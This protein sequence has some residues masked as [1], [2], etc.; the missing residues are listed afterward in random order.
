MISFSKKRF[1]SIGLTIS[2]YCRAF[3]LAQLIVTLVSMPILIA[4]GIPLSTMTFV[5]NLLFTPFISLFLLCSS[6]LFFTELCCIPNQLIAQ[7]VNVLGHI[8]TQLLNIGS[9]TWLIGFAHP[10]TSALVLLFI[11]NIGAMIMCFQNK[12]TLIKNLCLLLATN[13]ILLLLHNYFFSAHQCIL[14]ASGGSLTITAVSPGHLE[15]VDHGVLS[16][17][18]NARSF[19][20]YD[21]RPFL[22]KQF[23][24]HIIDRLVLSRPSKTAIAAAHELGTLCTIISLVCKGNCLTTSS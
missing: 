11:G 8:I 22:L 2:R 12:Q 3:L 18:K 13:I 1:L 14:T 15:I 24:N 7:L 16:K 21:L 10:P 6:L 4:W 23:G 5:G 19:V 20:Q 9:H 17:K